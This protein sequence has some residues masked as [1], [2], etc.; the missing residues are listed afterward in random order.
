MPTTIP[1]GLQASGLR[2]FESETVQRY[3]S[4]VIPQK[5]LLNPSGLIAA[6]SLRGSA[7]LMVLATF[8]K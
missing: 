2:G 6:S 5:F 1:P 7:L 3:D 8:S 4:K